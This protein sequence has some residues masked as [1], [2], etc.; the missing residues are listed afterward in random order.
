MVSTSSMCAGSSS[1]ART[2]VTVK[3]GEQRP[4]QRI[5]I[6]SRHRPKDLAFDALHREQRHER[7]DRDRRR[8][9]YRL[10]DLQRTDKDHTQSLGPAMGRGGLVMRRGRI[11]AP[12]AFAEMLQ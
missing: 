2:G 11:G 12:V 3:S 1:A 9:K 6:G 8:E 5:A 7:R 4:G 10:V